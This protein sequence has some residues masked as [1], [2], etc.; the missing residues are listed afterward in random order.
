LEIKPVEKMVV[1]LVILKVEL[2][3]GR[4]AAW[5]VLSSVETMEGPLGDKWVENLVECSENKKV[6]LTVETLAILT[7]ASKAEWMDLLSGKDSA[8]M[9]GKRKFVYWDSM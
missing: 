4:L 9:K 5:T 3:V 6:F 8:V 1:L 2:M 7:V